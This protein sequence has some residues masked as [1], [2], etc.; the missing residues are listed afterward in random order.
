DLDQGPVRS[1]W[2]KQ[3]EFVLTMIGYAVGLG[4]V[5]RFPYLCF[6]NGGGAFLI[7]YTLSLIFLGIPLFA[8][9]CAFGQYGGKGP[10]S[11]W[12]INPTFKGESS[13]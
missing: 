2:G 13:R 12:S 9:E 10:L 7:P 4:N 3:I 8:L 6:K 1:Q 11:I 5:W